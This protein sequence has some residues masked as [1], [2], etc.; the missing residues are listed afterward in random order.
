MI[1]INDVQQ[2]RSRNIRYTDWY[3][4]WFSNGKLANRCQVLKNNK[5]SF[6]EYKTS[7]EFNNKHY[8]IIWF[9]ERYKNINNKI[10]T[11]RTKQK[12]FHLWLKKYYYD[13]NK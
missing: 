4:M 6:K 11:R 12:E 5:Y 3:T 7:Y 2:A 10:I 1:I 9:K 8:T 13:D